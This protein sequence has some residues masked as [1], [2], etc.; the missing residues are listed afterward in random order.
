MSSKNS[1]IVVTFE[2]KK[3]PHPAED[4]EHAQANFSRLTLDEKRLKVCAS[5]NDSHEYQSPTRLCLGKV[6]QTQALE[7]TAKTN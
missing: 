6:D 4:L 7:Q 2:S 3:R 5:Q 1:K